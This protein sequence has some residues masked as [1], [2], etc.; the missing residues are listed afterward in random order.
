[1]YHKQRRIGHE[2]HNLTYVKHLSQQ[3][4][5]NVLRATRKALIRRG[6]ID[7]K[8][9]SIA[10]VMGEGEDTIENVKRFVVYL[11]NQIGFY[12]KSDKHAE[13]ALIGHINS[14]IEQNPKSMYTEL[15]PLEIK[16]FAENVVRRF[17]AIGGNFQ[18][19]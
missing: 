13:L 18:Y 9:E 7:R 4:T 17:K 16:E 14:V 5:Q 19:L 6:N 2:L 3:E 12:H 11:M 15:K 10:R 1:M 8:L